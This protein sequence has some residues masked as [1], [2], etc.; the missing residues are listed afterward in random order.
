[1]LEKVPSLIA[2][3]PPTCVHLNQVARAAVVSVETQTR[4]WILDLSP[5]HIDLP[6]LVASQTVTTVHP[7]IS[8]SPPR[9]ETLSRLQVLNLPRCSVEH[10]V[11]VRISRRAP[12]EFRRGKRVRAAETECIAL[13]SPDPDSLAGELRQNA[14]KS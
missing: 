4:R 9:V 8:D 10:P 2:T 13:L 7:S 5:L 12:I 11:L 1:M 6:I 3:D 14:F